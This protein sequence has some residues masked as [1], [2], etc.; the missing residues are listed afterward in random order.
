VSSTFSGMPI[1]FACD[2]TAI[3]AAERPLHHQLTR[4]LMDVAEIREL[5]DGFAFHFPAD[6][7]EAVTQFIGRERLCCPFLTFTLEIP[8]ESGPL[9]LRLTGPDGIK[10]F[11]R[12]E[13][14][15]ERWAGRPSTR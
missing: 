3:P 1:V 5:A 2:M 12:A 14:K 15:L 6:E 11:I 13:L 7:Y 9:V 4:R 8:Q 10:D